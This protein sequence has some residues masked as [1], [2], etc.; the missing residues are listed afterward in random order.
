MHPVQT[1]GFPPSRG[2]TMR[3]NIGWNPISNAELTIAVAENKT[4]IAA[5][6]ARDAAPLRAAAAAATIG[7][8]IESWLTSNLSASQ[9]GG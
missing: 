6:R 1:A 4:T 3:A 9:D 7:E 2:N 8:S 5:S